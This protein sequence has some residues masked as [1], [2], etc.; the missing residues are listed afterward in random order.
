M[1]ILGL[2]LTIHLHSKKFLFIFLPT[3]LKFRGYRS[4]G[5]TEVEIV[6]DEGFRRLDE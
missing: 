4:K 6:S 5:T 2:P 3:D 1:I